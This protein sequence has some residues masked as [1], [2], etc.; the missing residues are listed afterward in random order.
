MLGHQNIFRVGAEVNVNPQFAVRAGYQ[1][2]SSPYKD[3]S[4]DDNLNIGSLG[5]GY[6][7]SCGS[8]CSFFM[9]LTFQK[10]LKASV[11]EFALYGDTNIAAP[12]GVT[13]NDNW[14]LLLSLGLRF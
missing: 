12:V 8:S 11:E 2:Y 9:D 3:A 10:Q 13:K 6:V 5:V 14:K 4:A 7:A 1:H